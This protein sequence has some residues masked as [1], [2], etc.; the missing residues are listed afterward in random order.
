MRGLRAAVSLG[1]VEK[2]ML[3]TYTFKGST[4]ITNVDPSTMA[5]STISTS[6]VY[7]YNSTDYLHQSW[8]LDGKQSALPASGQVVIKGYTRYD[9]T[10]LQ[11]LSYSFDYKGSTYINSSKTIGTVA[12]TPV[13][14][15]ADTTRVSKSTIYEY[16]G[17]YLLDT[18][19]IKGEYTTP[20]VVQEECLYNLKNSLKNT[21]EKLTMFLS[22]DKRVI[23]L[24]GN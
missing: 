2:K 7:D 5:S 9:D 8:K 20:A 15:T 6:E 10:D 16:S 12:G 1:L 11:K 19:V 18:M 23:L 13:V 14:F 24:L 21:K 3:Y 22:L 4:A 17:D